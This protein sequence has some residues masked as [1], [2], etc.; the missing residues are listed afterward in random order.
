M[1][2]KTWLLLPSSQEPG[3]QIYSPK[4]CSSHCWWGAGVQIPV[5]TWGRVDQ[6]Y[7]WGPGEFAQEPAAAS[8]EAWAPGNTHILREYPLMEDRFHLDTLSWCQTSDQLRNICPDEETSS[9]SSVM[10][11]PASLHSQKRSQTE[12]LPCGKGKL[13]NRTRTALVQR[14]HHEQT[15]QLFPREWKL[16]CFKCWCL[17]RT[18]GR[19]SWCSLMSKDNDS[20]QHWCSM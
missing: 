8:H 15:S 14:G 18:K 5:L 4:V 3:G 11:S 13:Q 6:G 9:V 10:L 17:S 16:T 19:C 20:G 12:H 7:N 2:E 1:L